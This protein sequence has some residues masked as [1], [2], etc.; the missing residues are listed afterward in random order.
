MKKW[1]VGLVGTGY[2]SINHLHAWSQIPEV[3]IT[4]L[5]DQ[6]PKIVQEK[7]HQFRVPQNRIFTN[8]KEM[9]EKTDID[10]VDIVTGPET[11]LPMVKA[12]AIAGKHV[13]CQKPVAPTMEDAEAIVQVAKNGGIRLMVTE[14]W[15]WMQ[16]YQSLKAVLEQGLHGN[17]C[18][19]RY[20]HKSF[21]TPLM[22]PDVLL[23]QPFFRTMPRLLFYEN[24]S[25][26]YDTWRFLFGTPKRIY[27]NLGKVSPYVI[28][29]DTG[30]VLLSHKNFHG[31]MDMSWATG[32]ELDH[33]PSKE[34]RNEWIEQMVID[35]DKGTIK[36][37]STGK[38]KEGRIT[39]TGLNGFE[40]IIV[41]T[42]LADAP[43]SHYRL[44][45]H[46]IK[47]LSTGEQFQTE[48]EYNLVTMKLVFATYESAEQNQPIEI[49]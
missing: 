22:R 23:P 3:E 45:S 32:E 1:K 16:P 35:G 47:C 31:H 26:W 29:E 34:V 36:M 38:F 44:Q 13:L 11:H 4:A 6:N 7:A 12:A 14:N 49:N 9:L 24:G 19:V 40:E 21:Y 17:I 27:A 15:R 5:C 33:V 41:P 30:I 20:R 43:K 25:H 18:S 10:I 2:W 48:G 8:F 37:Y 39:F 28:G 46:F 42:T